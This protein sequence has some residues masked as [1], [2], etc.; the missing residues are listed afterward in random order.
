M[1]TLLYGLALGAGL[2][3]FPVAAASEPKAADIVAAIDRTITWQLAHPSGTP[4]RDWVIAPLYDGL[5]QAALATGKPQYL[6]PVLRMGKQSG[7]TLG[8][9]GRFADDHAVGHAWLDVYLMNRQR[10]ERLAPIQAQMSEIADHP[11]TEKLVYHHTPATPGVS[12][13]DR[14]TWS[15]ALYMGPPV[16]AR[17]YTAT[18]DSKYLDHLDREYRATVDH[19]YDR[20]EHLFYRD[21]N[22]IEQRTPRGKKVFWSRGNGWVYAALPQILEHMPA[23]D[24]RRRY[25]EDLFRDMTIGIL[26]AQQPDGLWRPSLLDPDEVPIGE[27]SGSGFFVYG[28]AWGINHGL[29]DRRQTWPALKRGWAGLMTRVRPDG[30]V[31]YVQPIGSA[32]RPEHAYLSVMPDGTRVLAP[33]VPRVLSATSTQDYGTGAFLLAASE[34][35]R[36]LGAARPVD[37]PA[38]LVRAEALLAREDGK[39][40]AYARV[41]PERMD[42][43]AWENDKVAFRMYGPALR[44]GAEDSGIDAWFK[45]V[46][47][48]VL[49]K[50]YGLATGKAQ[51][52]YHVDRGE[53]Y[54][55]YHVGDT[56]GVGGLGLW[57]DGKLV[58]SDTFVKGHVHWTGPDV[59]EFSNVFVYPL[60]LNGKPVYEHRYSRLRLGQ[61]MTEIGSYFSHSAGPY[62][63]HPI[64]DFPYEVVI[65]LVTQ[66]AA[67][68]EMVLDATRGLIA[69]TEPVDGK[70]LGTGVLL[71]PARV[72]R[73]ARLPA[74]DRDGK[75]AHALVL[76]RV[77]AGGYV[78]YRSG[79]AWSGDGEITQPQQWLSYLSRQASLSAAAPVSGAAAQLSVQPAVQSTV[80]PAAQSAAKP[81]GKPAAGTAAQAASAP[82]MPA[83]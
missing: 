73:T 75:H 36:T 33:Q 22:F 2:H 58:T 17:L 8:S 59:A 66:D 47:Y 30:H 23:A 31:G 52:S 71:D 77:D 56:R 5:I 40:R 57:V 76:T 12:F 81:G 32:P 78:R 20:T 21:A 9:R 7:W 29:L 14:W 65:G 70:P 3:C 27:T 4:L 72:V 16:F 67:R 54:D 43:L 63:A 37:R 28:L 34:M 45:K 46:R 74:A 6:A 24:P 60:T 1:R 44:A 83:H 42:D 48:P 26:K 15:D 38:L 51:Q 55:A 19:L 18:G 62:D 68:A 11:I 61:R 64:A 41:V 69:V 79:F 39:P 50:W 82:H 10:T 13:V 25:Y 49:D 35:L 53:G 80:L